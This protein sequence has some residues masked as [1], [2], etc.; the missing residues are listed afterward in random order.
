MSNHAKNEKDRSKI[1]CFW[2]SQ[3]TGCTKAY[4][5]FM[6]GKSVV[7]KHEP[8]IPETVAP[9]SP[10]PGSNPSPAAVGSK[11]IVNKNV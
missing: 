7:V 1:K 10:V 3:P 4:C 8:Y 6:H 2:E 9:T 11:I 5:P